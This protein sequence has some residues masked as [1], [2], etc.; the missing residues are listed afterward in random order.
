MSNLIASTPGGLLI[1]GFTAV[2][3]APTNVAPVTTDAFIEC[4]KSVAPNVSCE[5]VMPPPLG[6][7]P[8]GFTGGASKEY[9]VKFYTR[10]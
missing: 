5:M 7:N 1:S 6:P 10:K 8:S 9:S 3:S 2:V 4:S